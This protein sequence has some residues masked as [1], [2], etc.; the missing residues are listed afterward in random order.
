MFS[1]VMPV[2]NKRAF[3]EATVASVLAQDMQA[4]ELIAVD[5]GSTDG[6]LEILRGLTDPRIRVI[7]QANA[8]P[9][10][11]RNVGIAAARHDWVAF[12]DA[13]DLWLPC[14]LSELDRIRARFRDPGLIG[15]SFSLIP[16]GRRFAP[17]A[18]RA[19]RI[20]A[21]DYLLVVAHG[22]TPLITSSS[23]IHRQVYRDVGGFGPFP[24]NQDCEFW[25]RIALEHPV[26]ISDRVT[27]GYL[28]GTG[29]ITDRIGSRRRDTPVRDARDLSPATSMLI[30][31]GSSLGS[32][33]MQRSIA[34]YIAAEFRHCARKSA[35]IGD[36][37]TLRSLR[38]LYPRPPGPVDS[39]LFGI[40]RLPDP[41]AHAVCR[42]GFPVWAAFRPLRQRRLR[43]A[44]FKGPGS[45]SA[46]RRHAVG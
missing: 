13:D 29:G 37:E 28:T 36:I 17:R 43:R 31:R 34:R 45:A 2:W 42:V 26:A 21:I 38:K 12:L 4:F 9:G 35:R 25:A 5:D 41:I 39:L 10:A 6:S 46:G 15:S 27:V 11:A 30:D 19:G 1:I 24:C 14:H 16:N 44:L 3:L 7:A 20:G 23:A 18:G 32:A 22:A 8:G 40:A 33:E